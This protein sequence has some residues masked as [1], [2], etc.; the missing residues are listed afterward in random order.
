MSSVGDDFTPEQLARG[1][2]LRRATVPWSLGG[3]ATSLAATLILGFTPLGAR[4]VQA[5]G[6]GSRQG[7]ILLGALALLALGE[8]V[9]AP[10]S[11][12]V[13]VLRRAYG[14]VT[15]TWQGYLVDLARGFALSAAL[16]AAVVEALYGLTAWSARWWWLPAAAGAGVL[17]VLFSFLWPLLVEPVFNR[18]TPMPDGE[19]RTALLEL[20]AR[21]GVRVRDVL[22]ADASRRTTALNAYVSGL[23]ATRRIVVYDTLLETAGPRDVELV[24]AHE[25]GHV[26]HR[27]V[28]RG[29]ALGAVGSAAGVCVLGALT[30]W[31]P[32]L[33]AAGVHSVADP[34]SL[35][36]VAAL[37]ALLGTV[38]G[39]PQAAVSRR[40]EARA[41]RHALDATG[42]PG[43][44]VAMQRGL[45]V[46]NV[47]DVDPP[48]WLHRLFG[49]HPTTVQRIAAA[50]AWRA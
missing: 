35:P 2:A 6:L 11:A 47:A 19:L 30:A 42:D 24:V 50:R 8:A 26:V 41:D 7:E 31:R 13:R 18:F 25:L 20:A 33:D 28:A 12:R 3:R 34:R 43:A 48:R 22:V 14:L 4:L 15:Q 16:T 10:F 27:D 37:V 29:T 49:T 36:L 9:S 45:A 46:A 5:V 32:L 44:F 38:G 39:P 21:D 40:I 1:R 23:G 17:A